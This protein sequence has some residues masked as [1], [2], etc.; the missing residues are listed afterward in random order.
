MAMTDIAHRTT[1]HSNNSISVTVHLETNTTMPRVS[2]RQRAIRRAKAVLNARLLRLVID[3][4]SDSDSVEDMF[5]LHAISH[6]ESVQSKRYLERGPYRT[7]E[8]ANQRFEEDLYEGNSE[9]ESIP[10]LK[11]DEFLYKYRMTR[12]SFKRIVDLIKDNPLFASKGRGKKQRSVSHQLLVALKFFGSEGNAQS[13]PFL[14]DVFATGRGTNG[15]YIKRVALALQSLKDEVVTWPNNQERREISK[16]LEEPTGL[17]NCIAIMDGS[18]FPIAFEPETEDAPDYKGRK[19]TYSTTC[20]VVCDDKMI[21]RY[22]KAGWPGC[23]HDNR[24]YRNSPLYLNP[25]KYFRAHEYIMGDS[26]YE[27]GWFTVPAFRADGG[28]IGN[29]EET[30]NTHLARGRVRSEI[31]IGILKGRF[32]WLRSMRK[33]ITETLESKMDL[34]TLIDATFVLHNLLLQFKEDTIPDDWM[35]ENDNAS[36]IDESEAD[37]ILDL[38]DEVN[39]A[40]PI[41]S[42]DLRRRQLMY[43]LIEEY[44]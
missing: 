3:D 34:L 32:P 33:K 42:G 41:D 38:D 7:S 26:A 37:P 2:K 14:K 40:V 17:P 4:S 20:L 27:A 30:F 11:E 18:L 13:N 10:F 39:R 21:V 12:E 1:T 22:Y 35:D 29:E 16:R 24:V 8:R 19:H 9:T 15:D 43:R 31:C 28:S 25:D 6:L 23:A 44:Y 36:A 5:D